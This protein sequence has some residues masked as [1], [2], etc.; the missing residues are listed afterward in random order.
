MDYQIRPVDQ[1]DSEWVLEVVRRWGADFVVTR[2]RK[3]Y[4]Q[5]LDGFVAID[6]TG[7]R[8]GLLTYEVVGNQCE[9]VTLDAFEKFVGIGTALIGQ[10]CRAAARQ[11]CRRVW[12]ITT[13]DN[14]DAIRFYQRRGFAIAAV[15]TD[16]L[17]ESRRLKPSIPKVGLY[18]IPLSDEIEFE[19]ML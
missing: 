9:I 5:E 11:G 18:G 6:N 15:H 7:E 10:V 1:R 19:M 14:L 12:L 2:G 8:A 16:A 13:N 4:P 17:S 3:V